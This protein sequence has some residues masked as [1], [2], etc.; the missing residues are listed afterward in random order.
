MHRA[1]YL[2]QW[3]D[4]F[5]KRHANLP[6]AIQEPPHPTVPSERFNGMM[7]QPRGPLVLPSSYWQERWSIRAT[8]QRD[9]P[10]GE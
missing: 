6:P 4:D 8:F 9:G 3:R 7:S 1:A 10:P 2:A 5:V